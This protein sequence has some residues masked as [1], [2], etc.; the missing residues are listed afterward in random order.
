MA[1]DEIECDA[2]GVSQAVIACIHV[3]RAD[4]TH[5]YLMRASGDSYMQAWCAACEDARI[6]DRGWN[7]RAEEVAQ[8]SIICRACLDRSLAAVTCITHVAEDSWLVRSLG[9]FWR[10]VSW[11]EWRFRAWR[12]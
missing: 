3:V 11:A 2:H 12:R 7:E 4:A 6:A 10:I 5:V 1:Q 8:L 9:R